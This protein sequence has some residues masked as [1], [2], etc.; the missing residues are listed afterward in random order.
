MIEIAETWRPDYVT[1]RKGATTLAIAGGT[2]PRQRT[3]AKTRVLAVSP[4]IATSAPMPGLSPEAFIEHSTVS[5]AR[6]IHKPELG[7][8][9]EGSDADVALFESDNGKLG[10]VLTIR[11]GAVVWDPEGLATADWAVA[12][13]YTNFK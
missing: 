8:L 11:H 3:R 4:K 5:A 1:L 13:T 9:R 2:I 6:T 7:A 12:G 10:C